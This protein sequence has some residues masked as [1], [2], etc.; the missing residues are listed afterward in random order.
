MPWHAFILNMFPRKVASPAKRTA[1]SFVILAHSWQLP[2][3]TCRGAQRGT[4]FRLNSSNNEGSYS[5]LVRM[6]ALSTVRVWMCMHVYGYVHIYVSSYSDIHC[7][8]GSGQQ[9]SCFLLCIDSQPCRGHILKTGKKNE[10]WNLIVEPGYQ[11][12]Q[13]HK[14]ESVLIMEVA[15]FL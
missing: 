1:S 9:N 10:W 8:Y 14:R 13:I 12:Y 15:L 3:E 4:I 5:I 7:L 2:S 6:L 11:I